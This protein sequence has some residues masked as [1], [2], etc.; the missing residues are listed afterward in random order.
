MM[1][2][3]VGKMRILHKNPNTNSSTTIPQKLTRFCSQTCL[4]THTLAFRS[5]SNARAPK[6]LSS[7]SNILSYSCSCGITAMEWH[8]STEF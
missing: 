3:N 5:V 7:S 2:S 6:V 1:E 8:F 4:P